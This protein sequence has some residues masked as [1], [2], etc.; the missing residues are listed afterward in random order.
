[1]VRPQPTGDTVS[2]ASPAN[3]TVGED[4]DGNDDEDTNERTPLNPDYSNLGEDHNVW[5]N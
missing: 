4:D 5:G 3:F 1:M 2:P